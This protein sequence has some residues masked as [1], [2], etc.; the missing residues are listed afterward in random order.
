MKETN[1]DTNCILISGMLT[2][3]AEATAAS[4]TNFG[5]IP[6]AFCVY[7]FVNEF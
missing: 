6:E 3:F 4:G 1:R 7:Y 2:Q 5:K